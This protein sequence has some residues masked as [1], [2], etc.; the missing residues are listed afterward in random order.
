[1]ISFSEDKVAQI[2]WALAESLEMADQLDA[3]STLV[4]IE[5]TFA[6]VRARFDQRGQE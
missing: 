3:L 4:L 1:M 6:V 5:D 2:L